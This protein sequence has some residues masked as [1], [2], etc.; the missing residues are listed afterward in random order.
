MKQCTRL[1]YT[2]ITCLITEALTS[3]SLQLWRRSPGVRPLSSEGSMFK[4]LGALGITD[5]SGSCGGPRSRYSPPSVL[6][7]HLAKRPTR[8]SRGPHRCCSALL[9]RGRPFQ[10]S[11]QH[12][13]RVSLTPGYPEVLAA[14]SSSTGGRVVSVP[15]PRGLPAPLAGPGCRAEGGASTGHAPRGRQR[16]RGPGR[17]IVSRRIDLTH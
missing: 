17:T 15:L 14:S 8:T 4:L 6:R 3:T 9:P 7:R 5:P 13:Q 12:R 1:H 10:R 16:D 2:N 11:H